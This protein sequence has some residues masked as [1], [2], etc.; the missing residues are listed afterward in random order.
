MPRKSY[1]C[2]KIKIEKIAKESSLS[3]TF[4]KRRFGLFKKVSDICTLCGVELAII[5]LSPTRKKLY[6][7]GNPSVE[8]IVDCFMGESPD[9]PKSRTSEIMECIRNSNIEEL[10]TQL[11]NMLGQLESEKKVSKELK[12]IRKESQEN[13]WWDAPIEELGME[14]L[15]QLKV[16]MLELKR[17]TVEAATTTPIF[18]FFDSTWM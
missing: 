4:S 2:Q 14:E 6:S 7:F 18:R 3:V 8:V 16:V 13:C 9:P 12:K 11:T 15:E 10:N 1:G 17:L 5:V